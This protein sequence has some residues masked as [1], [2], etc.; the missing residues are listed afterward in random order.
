[1]GVAKP[2]KDFDKPWFK[3]DD[4]D[5]ERTLEQQCL[6]LGHMFADCNGKSVL[7]VGCAE[8]LIAL[9]ATA[10][11]ARFAHGVELV[12]S[13]VQ[14][15]NDLAFDRRAP[16]VFY[17]QAAENFIPPE[18]QYDIVLMLAILHKM[19]NPTAV[20]AMYADMCTDLCVIRLPPETAPIIIDPRS[21]NNPHNIGAVMAKHGFKL[22]RV[23]QGSF[24]EWCGYYRKGYGNN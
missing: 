2:L 8:G 24:N 1:M 9:H 21:D 12:Q 20:C 5:S 3:L 14:A 17:A 6:G 11:G 22:E 7:D 13:R 23:T 18:P 4:R 19:K 10:C 15:A 16:A